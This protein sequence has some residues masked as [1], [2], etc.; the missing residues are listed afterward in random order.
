MAA[1]RDNIDP[2]LSTPRDEIRVDPHLRHFRRGD[3][4]PRMD[5]PEDGGFISGV[6]FVPPLLP[7]FAEVVGEGPAGLRVLSFA[8]GLL[9]LLDCVRAAYV[10]SKGEGGTSSS[11]GGKIV[12][13]VVGL[14]YFIFGTLGLLMVFMELKFYGFRHC[15]N[16]FAEWFKCLTIPGGKGIYY[17]FVGLLGLSLGIVSIVSCIVGAVISIIGGLNVGFHVVREKQFYEERRSE[18]GNQLNDKEN[19]PEMRCDFANYSLVSNKAKC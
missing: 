4:L 5:R 11:E 6:G 19:D 7:T 1:P 18:F 2:R 12:T 13:S 8:G 16:W 3:T 15:R 14:L 17:L 10:W 9:I